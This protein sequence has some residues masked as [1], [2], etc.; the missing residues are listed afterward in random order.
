MAIRTLAS[1]SDP[2]AQVNSLRNFG[3]VMAALAGSWRNR[4]DKQQERDL[5]Q[6]RYLLGMAQQEP[7]L[8]ADPKFYGDVTSRYGKTFPEVA[9]LL[10]VLKSRGAVFQQ[11]KV[12]GEKFLSAQGQMQQAHDALQQQISVSPDTLENGA[13][14]LDKAI[15]T[16]QL[17]Q[18]GEPASFATRAL[19]QLSPE[20]RS[21]ATLY[22]KLG[23]YQMPRQFDPYKDMTPEGKTLFAGETGALDPGSPAYLAAQYQS[24]L[25]LSP[26]TVLEM[27]QK[28]EDERAR[29]KAAMDLEAQR[30]TDAQQGRRE[31]FDFAKKRL[32]LQDKLE[33]G[34]MGLGVTNFEQKYD[35]THPNGPPDPTKVTFKD[36]VQGV[37]QAQQD[38]DARLKQ[39]LLGAP[40][41][42]AAEIKA[43]FFQ[44]YGSRPAP[45]PPAHAKN[46]ALRAEGAGQGDPDATQQALSGMVS[47]YQALRAAGKSPTEALQAAQPG[48]PALTPPPAPSPGMSAPPKPAATGSSWMPHVDWGTGN[49]TFGQPAAPAAGPGRTSAP[50]QGAPQP[51]AAPIN[52]AQSLVNAT[53]DTLVSHGAGYAQKVLASHFGIQGA[54]ADQLLQ[55]A[56][57]VASQRQLASQQASIG[58][59]T[60]SGPNSSPPQD[61]PD[62]ASEPDEPE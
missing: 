59:A 2:N 16:G 51:S 36:I 23:G 24:R 33:R 61:E 34:R 7:E 30:F 14:N 54:Q 32:G 55:A 28:Q 60:D 1:Y 31:T 47:N 9:P 5:Q 12:A 49:I 6:I 21:G 27:A 53:A 41:G 15:L 57:A 58:A 40:K 56:Q 52:P 35:Y 44:Q 22:Q 39:A 29:A 19:R 50:P 62:N 26:V 48:A 17:A 8:A 46:L 13:P 18:L 45:I 42:K 11:A 4:Q 38:Y 3:A 37:A 25:K 20:E 10:D 43:A